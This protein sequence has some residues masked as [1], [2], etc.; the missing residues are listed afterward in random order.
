MGRELVGRGDI[1]TA[2]PVDIVGGK[3]YNSIRLADPELSR[4]L[5]YSVPEFRIVTVGAECTRAQAEHLHSNS[6]CT[7]QYFSRR[8]VV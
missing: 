8:F 4:K 6:K 7:T 5:G 2:N 3:G 1:L